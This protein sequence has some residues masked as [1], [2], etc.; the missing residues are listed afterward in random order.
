MDIDKKENKKVLMLMMIVIVLLISFSSLSSARDWGIG[1]E[2]SEEIFNYFS[3]IWQPQ[4]GNAEICDL[5]NTK[6]YDCTAYQC[7][8]LGTSCE[9][10]NKGTGFE[11]CVAIERSIEPAIITVL[12]TALPNED[13]YRYITEGASSPEERGA[14]IEYSETEEGCIK[15]NTEMSF[16]VS[17]D[18]YSECRINTSRGSAFENMAVSMS[19]GAYIKEHEITIPSASLLSNEELAAEGFEIENDRSY[20]FYVRCNTYDG[21][22]NPVDFSIEFCVDTGPD[23]TPPN[24]TEINY[25]QGATGGYITFNASEIPLRLTTH[26]SANCKWAFE[27][28]EYEVMD[29]NLTHCQS[30]IQTCHETNLPG[31]AP[32]EKKEYYFRCI[33]KPWWQE[34]DDGK[35]FA[36]PSSK[37]LTLFGTYPL[38]IQ[39]ITINDLENGS[40]IK[41][42]SDPIVAS[43]KVKTS[44]GAN[45]GN[46]NCY[47]S[48]NQNTGFIQ[49]Y[50]GGNFDYATEAD[51]NLH[52]TEGIHTYYI[53]CEDQAANFAYG[54]IT[55]TI[56]VDKDSPQV[57]RIYKE[58]NKL[59]LITDEEA[60]CVYTTTHCDYPY[61]EGTEMT[62]LE[63]KNHYI[64][65]NSDSTI[66]VKCMDEFGN[67]PFYQS[68]CSTIVRPYGN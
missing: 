67:I 64:N 57:V 50:S 40:T 24:I 65:W 42:A 54:N 38:E 39:K 34:G 25:N 12:E 44:A 10:I 59:K 11:T 36:N 1:T 52:L 14:I 18:K 7:H 53:K 32:G 21:V 27:D 6:R 5:C 37:I 48:E 19:G 2:K 56:D 13:Y 29:Y 3:N 68:Q 58:Q 47:Y 63:R 9:F 43:L 60:Q 35:R 41:D 45:E 23:T 4:S 46:A 30:S 28:K 17:T 55:F 66:F 15:P 33:D 8:S 61:E 62:T 51:Q 26:E 22:P 49:F 31:L 20:N 16:G